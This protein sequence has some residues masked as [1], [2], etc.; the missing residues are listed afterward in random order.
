MLLSILKKI[1]FVNS[2]MWFSLRSHKS[3]LM[4]FFVLWILASLP[5]WITVLFSPVPDEGSS[6]GRALIER[7]SAAI[8]V[9]EQF[10]YVAS[11]LTPVLYIFY[12]K[13]RDSSGDNP[14]ERIGQSFQVFDG[15]GTVFLA[16]C[17]MILFTGLAFSSI[18]TSPE[19]F[20]STYLYHFLTTYSGYLYFFALFCWYLSLLDSVDKG[21]YVGAARA[22]ERVVSKGLAARVS[23]RREN[24]DE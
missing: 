3:A 5:V 18:K 23:G 11:F 15:Y 9:S 2:L 13:Y 10:V 14:K 12:E 8:S 1:P 19:F 16:S 24:D 7:F 20:Q 22:G 4:K 6:W 21:D 17:L